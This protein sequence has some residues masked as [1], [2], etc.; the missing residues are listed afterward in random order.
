MAQADTGL[1]SSRR[2]LMSEESTV[3]GGSRP[4]LLVFAYACE[5]G[6]GSEPG[7]GWSL[8]Q[9]VA[10]FANPVVLVGPEHID[11]IRQWELDNPDS[12]IEFQL[13][14]EPGW[15]RWLPHEPTDKS[16]RHLIGYFLSYLGWQ[17]KAAR[18]AR[19]L[20]AERQF[21]VAHHATYSV[22]WL[23]SPGRGLDTPLVWG[24]VGGAVTTP[25]NMWRALGIKGIA[26][27]ALDLVA[28]RLFSLAPSTRRTWRR[29]SVR[30]LQSEETRHRLGRERN[31]DLLLNHVMFTEVEREPKPRDQFML[32]LSSFEPRKGLRFALRGLAAA[33][34]AVR[35]IIV[36]DGPEREAVESLITELDLQDRVELR[37]WLP[38]PEAM[39]LLD[40]AGAV[41][42]AGVREEGGTALAEA[43]QRGA[44]VIVFANGGAKTVA[45]AAVDPDRVRLIP[46]G[47]RDEIAAGFGQAMTHFHNTTDLPN[48]PNLDTA[49]AHKQLEEA[50]RSA[51]G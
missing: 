42:F 19:S 48:T 16:R 14:P 4:R 5:P 45:E 22:Y 38:Y 18:V 41:V 17:R 21:D 39:D 32:F 28:V 25:L 26:S 33:D 36:G 6:R 7:V 40:R 23:P 35:M 2:H 27:E 15:A 11:A 3:P 31:D 30:L 13:V 37:G 29:A 44:P 43:M 9:S 24:P 12:P 47:T 49:A 51:M 50:I 1:G 20:H 46:P 8:V 34:P 10:R